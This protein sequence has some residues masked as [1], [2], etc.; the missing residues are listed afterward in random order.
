M[1]KY[2]LYI[3]HG[4]F[5]NSLTFGKA[6]TGAWRGLARKSFATA[7]LFLFFLCPSVESK[8]IIGGDLNYECVSQTATTVRLR[9]E[10]VLYRDQRDP[11]GADCD[12][13]ALFGVWTGSEGNWIYAGKTAPLSPQQGFLNELLNPPCADAGA[14]TS[15]N[16]PPN[17]QCVY[18]F[19]I[20]L[21]KID[22]NYLIAY[23]RCC[24]NEAISNVVDPGGFGAVFSIELTPEALLT[25]NNSPKFNPYETAIF[26]T[27]QQLIIDNNAPDM[28]GDSV[29]YAFCFP[30]SAG[31]RNS[32]DQFSCTYVK[33][34]PEICGPQE[35]IDVEFRSPT[36]SFSRPVL[37]NPDLALNRNTGLLAGNPNI[38]GEYVMAVCAEEY[39]DGIL[40]TKMRRDLQVII[41]DCTPKDALLSVSPEDEPFVL[42]TGPGGTLPGDPN[43][44]LDDIFIVRVCGETNVKFD[45]EN[46][47][48]PY[49]NESFLWFF[50]L[51]DKIIT[52]DKQ[53]PEIDFPGIGEYNGFMVIDP[54]SPPCSDTAFVEVKILPT[55][56]SVFELKFDDCKAGAIA[57]QDQSNTKPSNADNSIVGWKWIFGDGDTSLLRNTSHF[58]SSPGTKT[59]TLEVSD[60]NG[61]VNTSSQTFD[62]FPVPEPRVAP[63]GFLGCSP[64]TFQFENLSTPLD[65]NYTVTWDFGDGSEGPERFELHPNHTYLEPGQYDV[66]LRIESPIAGCVESKKFK[67]LI[68]VLQGFDADFDMNPEDPNII[69]QRVALT[70][71]SDPGAINFAWD[72]AGSDISYAEN[73]T[74]IVSDTGHHVVTLHASWENGCSAQ[75][76]KEFDIIPCIEVRFPNAFTPNG[77]GRNEVFKGLIFGLSAVNFR[78][79]IYDRWGKLIFETDDPQTGWNGQYLNSGENLPP[80]VYMYRVDFSNP[81]CE[82]RP[83]PGFATLL[84]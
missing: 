33:P 40:L 82:S 54:E 49:R 68:Q 6:F 67:D 79:A 56:A 60:N 55:V 31:G 10:M 17:E 84:R 50:D 65:D 16:I 81:E 9:F 39:R 29:H 63:D 24:R 36:F 76:T 52:S 25:C 61:C 13:D 7:C 37:G 53:S 34:D 59:V 66:T 5:L 21:P 74:F 72:F 28:D 46:V 30:V 69:G 70:N 3:V 4:N 73:P 43:R 41:T 23:Q 19:E 71:R 14:G 42:N 80:G 64:Q 57:F 47:S 38:L 1:R 77:D 20:D 78:L 26:C 15:A 2:I 12:L 44:P 8:H 35:F 48:E 11:E 62:W 51:G 75:A 32:M 45:L 22:E 18:R 27:N 83:K 58:Y